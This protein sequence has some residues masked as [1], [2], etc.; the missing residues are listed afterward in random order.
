MPS[1]NPFRVCDHPDP[2]TVRITTSD[3][4]E[5][6]WSMCSDCAEGM[7]HVWAVYTRQCPGA[8]VTWPVTD[9]A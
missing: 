9:A 1:L 8:L 6:R 3:G 7:R 4:A 5:T 2:V